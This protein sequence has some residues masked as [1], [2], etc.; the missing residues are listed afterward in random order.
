VRHLAELDRAL[1]IFSPGGY[2]IGV[3]ERRARLERT[4]EAADE[5]FESCDRALYE[6]DESD[7]LEARMAAYVRSHPAQFFRDE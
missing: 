4:G 3:R 2:P 6:L 1:S 7:P 5:L